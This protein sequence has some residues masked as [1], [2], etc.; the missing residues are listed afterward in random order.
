[1]S[2]LAANRVVGERCHAEYCVLCQCLA[3]NNC[4]NFLYTFR[5]S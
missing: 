3:F 1:M 2:W 5:L 4:P